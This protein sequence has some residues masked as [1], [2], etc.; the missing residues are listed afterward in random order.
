MTTVTVNTEAIDPGQ[1]A[2]NYYA[3]F[4]RRGPTEGD[5]SSSSAAVV[6]WSP[7]TTRVTADAEFIAALAASTG[8]KPVPV[9]VE[10]SG[11]G[12]GFGSGDVPIDPP[13]DRGPGGTGQV[14][15]AGGPT[16]TGG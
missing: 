2:V 11:G 8:G 15:N 5:P 14:P 7:T 16:G 6:D 3:R 4:V 12:E 10:A 13:P 9:L 1:F